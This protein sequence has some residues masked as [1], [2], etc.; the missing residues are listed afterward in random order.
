MGLGMCDFDYCAPRKD[1][2]APPESREAS[3]FCP[4]DG[5][6]LEWRNDL[7]IELESDKPWFPESLRGEKY[8]ANNNES[9][10]WLD[11]R[12]TVAKIAS[13]KV[14]D[15]IRQAR[16]EGYMDTSPNDLFT[17]VGN[18]CQVG[19]TNLAYDITINADAR[20]SKTIGQEEGAGA[21]VQD[22]GRNI[23]L[24][25]NPETGEVDYP[26]IAREYLECTDSDADYLARC[27]EVKSIKVIIAFREEDL[28]YMVRAP[29]EG[30]EHLYR[31]AVYD[32]T[33]VPF[34][35]NWEQGTKDPNSNLYNRPPETT[36]C[37]MAKGYGWHCITVREAG[38]P[39]PGAEPP[40]ST[41]C[42]PA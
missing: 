13:A 18:E 9:N 2:F 36:N 29:G 41:G 5:S 34:T 17:I 25:R 32:N 35:A 30:E 10:P 20:N 3:T 15:V 19:E 24:Y 7:P 37:S 42:K 22:P 33:Y 8:N 1:P 16:A 11:M 40:V 27:A 6:A 28:N 4:G 21:L 23:G 31:I 26:S 38:T 12:E 14:C 39:P